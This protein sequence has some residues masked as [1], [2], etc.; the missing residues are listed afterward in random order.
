MTQDP[1][2]HSMLDMLIGWL[3]LYTNSYIIIIIIMFSTSLF[4]N[5]RSCDNSREDQ[6]NQATQLVFYNPLSLSKC[7]R[8]STGS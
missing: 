6:P 1:N 3:F 4:P 5:L 7:L 8:A 2:D